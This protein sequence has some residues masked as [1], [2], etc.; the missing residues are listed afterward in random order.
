MRPARTIA[1]FAA[2]LL[3]AAS[4]QRQA[5]NDEAPAPAIEWGEPI[6]VASGDAHRG[7]WRMNDSD[8]RFVDDATVA[9]SDTGA[10]AVA[11]ADHV[12]QDVFLQV[13]ERSGEPRLREPLNISR[14]GDVFSW[15]PRLVFG[16]DD[17]IVMLWQEI[18][19]RGGS[20]GGEIYVARSTDGGHSFSEPKN[21][22]D[23]P[24]GAGK[25]RL[26]SDRWSNGSFD[27]HR[28]ADGSLHAA[29]TEYEGRLWYAR[30]SD[31]GQGFSE[32]LELAGGDAIGELPARGPSLAAGGGDVHLAYTVGDATAADIRVIS[33]IDGG[34]S[35]G[36]PRLVSP[37]G[38][39]ADAPKL[40]LDREQTLH[41]VF[42]EG[43]RPH[44]AYEIRY[45]RR[46]RGEDD[47]SA[48]RTLAAARAR[49][50]ASVHYPHIAADDDGR[51][52]VLWE[53]YPS[54]RHPPRGLDLAVSDDGG[55]SFG[56]PVFVPGSG[57]RELGFSGS[58]QGLLMRKL[59]VAGGRVAI[60][61]STFRPNRSSHI[62]LLLGDGPK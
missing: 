16:D 7:P 10:V 41:L 49:S 23:S 22:S 32:P 47:F 26:S 39:H 20:H 34:R 30:S 44:G 37:G 53:R 46:P 17:T 36:E 13:F 1:V 43:D 28:A 3:A 57:S 42:A 52:L 4:C 15:L 12:A 58:L 56:E 40:A 38:G 50:L 11:W 45:T 54:A 25:G 24:A 59:D 18:E 29:W 35:F 6:E 62:W 5:R 48:S 55:D 33:S 19:F 21:L 27:L 14:T 51:I 9:L 2:C 61:N 60:A 8:W 31:G